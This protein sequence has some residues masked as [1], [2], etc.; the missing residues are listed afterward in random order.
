MLSNTVRARVG[1]RHRL[2]PKVMQD[3]CEGL[4]DARERLKARCNKMN[5]HL[6]MRHERPRLDFGPGVAAYHE[7]IHDADASSCLD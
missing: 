3:F 6:R 2:A 1:F 7:L 5:V 4:S